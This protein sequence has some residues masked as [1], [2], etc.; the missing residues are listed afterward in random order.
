MEALQLTEPLEVRGW[1]LA[2]ATAH[3]IRVWWNEE[4][5]TPWASGVEPSLSLEARRYAMDCV[6]AQRLGTPAPP[7]PVTA[8][9]IVPWDA[10]FGLIELDVATLSEGDPV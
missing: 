3:G 4:R 10:Y 2:V 1:R 6:E 8:D 7:L 9:T 5:Q